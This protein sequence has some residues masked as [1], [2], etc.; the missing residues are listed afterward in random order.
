MPEAQVRLMYLLYASG[1]LKKH[2]DGQN[3]R[4]NNNPTD[5]ICSPNTAGTAH[6]RILKRRTCST[7]SGGTRLAGSTLA[8]RAAIP[9]RAR[10][11]N[12]H[13]T[14]RQSFARRRSTRIH[15]AYTPLAELILPTAPDEAVYRFQQAAQENDPDAHAALA[16]IYLQGKY[17]ERNHKLAL[18]HAEAAAAERHPEG[19]RILGDICRYGLGMPR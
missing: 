2:S 13:G 3:Q 18:H 15:S 12:R 19:L 10:D 8:A 9:F 14:G 11:E 6:R 5:N 17:Q 4:K 16:D 1:I 7:E